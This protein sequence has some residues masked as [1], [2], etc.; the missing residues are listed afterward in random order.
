MFIG[1]AIDIGAPAIMFIIENW[2]GHLTP[3]ESNSLADR[4]SRSDN[5]VVVNLAAKLALSCL[6]HSDKLNSHE[7]IQAI[8][9]VSAFLIIELQIFFNGRD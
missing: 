2:P 7:I 9:Q 5:P 4:G 1:L 8:N 3:S 6:S